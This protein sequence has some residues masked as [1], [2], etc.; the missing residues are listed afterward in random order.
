MTVQVFE[1]EGCMSDVRSGPIS[2]QT[3]SDQ[4]HPDPLLCS[5]LA[6]SVT[7]GSAL[8]WATDYLLSILFIIMHHLN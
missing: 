1:L 5:E 3:A 6:S 2:A 7:S 4:V 8:C